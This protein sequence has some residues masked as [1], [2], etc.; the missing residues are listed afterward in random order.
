MKCHLNTE[1][2]GFILKILMKTIL[3]V[4]LNVFRNNIN[5]PNK[6]LKFFLYSL[7]HIIHLQ[8]ML[9][10]YMNSLCAQTYKNWNWWI[11]DDS[12]PNKVKL[13]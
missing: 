12:S 9:N 7:V 11:I 4:L 1:K 3:I 5:R 2:N 10:V 8:T 6:I 13:F